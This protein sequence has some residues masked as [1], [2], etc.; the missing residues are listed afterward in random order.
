[1]A[2][3]FQGYDDEL[4]CRMVDLRKEFSIIS[5]RDHCQRSSPSQ[6]SDTPRIGFEPEQNLSSNFNE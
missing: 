1:M 4:F 2:R 5:S 6:I 3:E